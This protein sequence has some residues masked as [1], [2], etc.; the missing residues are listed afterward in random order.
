MVSFT[1]CHI[2][3]RNIWPAAWR[4]R[5]PRGGY[6]IGIVWQGQ[7][8]AKIG[9]GRSLSAAR[10]RPDCGHH[11]LPRGKSAARERLRALAVAPE[12][13][14]LQLNLANALK[15]QGRLEEAAEH[16]RDAVA[17]GPKLLQET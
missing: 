4:E 5:L 2:I 11:R 10:P 3:F 9:K 1:W 15:E 14:E 17:F 8:N 13:A 12:R 7:P 6:R 16:Y